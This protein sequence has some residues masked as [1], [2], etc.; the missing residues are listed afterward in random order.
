MKKALPAVLALALAASAAFVP[1][2]KAQTAS[3]T[4]HKS[5]FE[6]KTESRRLELDVTESH[7]V[8]RLALKLD[9]TGGEIKLRLRDP[10][11]NVRQDLVLTRTG[12][13][14]E[15]GTGGMEAIPGTWTAEV[16]LKGATGN[17]ELTLTA[18]RP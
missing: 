16:A 18:E 5:S 12:R 10:R 13:T 2:A 11:G 17:Y 3:Q 9:L 15:V 6:S 8:V 1:A 7:R 14:A 4:R